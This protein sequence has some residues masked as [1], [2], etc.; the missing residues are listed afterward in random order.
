VKRL[1]DAVKAIIADTRRNKLV[2]ETF[3]ANAIVTKT[4]LGGYLDI[5]GE[6]NVGLIRSERYRGLVEVFYKMQIDKQ[7][8]NSDEYEPLKQFGQHMFVD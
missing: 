8:V 5:M 6:V 3:S 7:Y 2:W 1:E 4:K